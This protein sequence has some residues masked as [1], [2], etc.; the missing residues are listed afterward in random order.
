MILERED[1]ILT[2]IMT[3]RW[4]LDDN[5]LRARE[6]LKTDGY[7]LLT[8]VDGTKSIMKELRANWGESSEEEKR[9]YQDR[10]GRRDREESSDEEGKR[11]AKGRETENEMARLVGTCLG[12]EKKKRTT[13]NPRNRRRKKKRRKNKRM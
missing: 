1:V 10:E 13:T 4:L 9:T 3:S 11:E 6:V 5:I 12:E 7:I 2:A 8:K